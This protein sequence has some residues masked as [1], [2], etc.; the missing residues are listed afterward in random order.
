MIIFKPFDKILGRNYNNDFWVCDFYNHCFKTSDNTVYYTGISGKLYTQC[1]PYEG[2][3]HYHQ[4]CIPYQ[5]IWIPQYKEIVA[6]SQ[7]NKTWTVGIFQYYEK[8]KDH[9]YNAGNSKTYT[10]SFKYCEPLTKHFTNFS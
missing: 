6:L 8:N 9:P 10:M 5:E 3:E 4:T 1:I 7:D 2:N